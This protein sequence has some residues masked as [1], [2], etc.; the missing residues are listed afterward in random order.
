LKYFDETLPNF[1]KRKHPRKGDISIFRSKVKT[2]WVFTSYRGT[3][4]V[5]AHSPDT[6]PQFLKEKRLWIMKLCCFPIFITK[7]MKLIDASN[8]WE[9]LLCTWRA[10]YMH[11]FP[12]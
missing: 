12:S 6:K 10:P 2:A 5:G 8:T 7:C 4:I 9:N 3:C 1:I 11:E